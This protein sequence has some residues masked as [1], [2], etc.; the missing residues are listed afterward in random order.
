V[1]DLLR[2]KVDDERLPPDP[3][4]RSLTNGGRSMVVRVW[5]GKSSAANADAYKSFQQE[6]AAIASRDWPQTDARQL[7]TN[8]TWHSLAW[9]KVRI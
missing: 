7:S 6:R 8:R 3:G 1:T 5:R 9:P 4:K 2:I